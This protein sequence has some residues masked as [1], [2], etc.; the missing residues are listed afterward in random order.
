MS[1]SS[2]LSTRV[3]QVFLPNAMCS[4]VLMSCL[5]RVLSVS[6]LAWSFSYLSD[7]TNFEAPPY[8]ISPLSRYFLAIW[9]HIIYLSC[10]RPSSD[11][12]DTRG[13]LWS[14]LFSDSRCKTEFLDSVES[15]IPLILSS[16]S[17]GRKRVTHI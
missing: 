15:S 2:K 11:P 3:F 14:H 10:E 1:S 13:K 5:T 6:L 17:R 9:V 16:T 4:Q 12:Q 7:S 8:A